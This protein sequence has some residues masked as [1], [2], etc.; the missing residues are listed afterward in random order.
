MLSELDWVSAGFRW[1]FQSCRLELTPGLIKNRNWLVAVS[2]RNPAFSNRW[3]KAVISAASLLEGCVTLTLVF[4][5]YIASMDALSTSL[6]DYKENILKLEKQRREQWNRLNK[7]IRNVG[8]NVT[9][10]A[11]Q[12]LCELISADLV[13]ELD[14]AFKN[15]ASRVRQLVQMQVALVHPQVEDIVVRDRLADFFLDEIPVLINYYYSIASGCVDVYPGPQAPFFWELDGGFLNDELPYA[16]SLVRKAKP[17]V[18]CHSSRVA[19]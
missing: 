5:P 2:L 15:P 12:E 16:S 17:H 8:C 4:E 7:L 11:W 6:S 9:L 14:V 1:C 13:D 3:L 18:Y 10:I 19:N